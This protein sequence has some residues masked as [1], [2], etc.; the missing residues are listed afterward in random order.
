MSRAT[1]IAATAVTVGLVL[2]T[3]PASAQPAPDATSTTLRGSRV[4]GVGG[5]GTMILRP[6]CRE[7]YRA[8]A[9]FD[10]VEGEDY[11]AV[12]NAEDGTGHGIIGGSREGTVTTSGRITL[13]VPLQL[14]GS[15]HDAGVGRIKVGLIVGDSSVDLHKRVLI[16]YRDR[17]VLT[18]AT[19]AR[20]GTTLRGA[21]SRGKGF[22]R[23]LTTYVRTS[24]RVQV[25][26]KPRGSSRWRHV[27]TTR[28]DSQGRWSARAPIA[29][30]GAWQARVAGS[31]RLLPATSQVRRVG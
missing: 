22:P 9:V 2:A 25:C 11:W 5:P 18:R 17:V 14:C 27:G 24:V 31:Q 29:R 6:G 4:V 12:V 30:A 19:H 23:G 7:S 8:A 15:D 10:A 21:W 16:K 3:A 26:F 13:T 28:I 1:S 20:G